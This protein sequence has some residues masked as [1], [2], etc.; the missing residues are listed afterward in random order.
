MPSCIVLISIK[1]SHQIWHG[2]WLWWWLLRDFVDIVYLCT[3][4][5]VYLLFWCCCFSDISVTMLRLLLHQSAGC[6]AML[7]YAL[8]ML[9]LCSAMRRLLLYN[10][11]HVVLIGL[12]CPTITTQWVWGRVPSLCTLLLLL[13]PKHYT[14]NTNKLYPWKQGAYNRSLWHKHRF[15][16]LFPLSA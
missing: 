1:K 14:W 6:S 15:Q 11:S 12:P 10:M 3:C 2:N 8:L 9:C 7:C 16:L 13:L 4:V 5:L